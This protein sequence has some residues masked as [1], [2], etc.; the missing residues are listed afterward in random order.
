MSSK[1]DIKGGPLVTKRM[2]VQQEPIINLLSQTTSFQPFGYVALR[3]TDHQQSLLFNV[4]RDSDINLDL[5][6]LLPEDE[7]LTTINEV[8]EELQTEDEGVLESET[9]RCLADF[10]FALSECEHLGELLVTSV[11]LRNP[12]IY[13]RCAMPDHFDRDGRLKSENSDN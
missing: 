12:E 1:T 3:S 8:E 2:R 10:H 9:N 13:E 11:L 4:Y 7:Q 6:H 5:D